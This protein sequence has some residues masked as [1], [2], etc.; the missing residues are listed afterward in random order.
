MSVPCILQAS[1]CFDF[2]GTMLDHLLGDT[3]NKDLSPTQMPPLEQAYAA[4]GSDKPPLRRP[5]VNF[6]RYSWVLSHPLECYQCAPC[7]FR[8]KGSQGCPSEGA[9]KR[10]SKDSTAAGATTAAGAPAASPAGAEGVAGTS[11]AVREPAAPLVE[12]KRR[13]T[14]AAAAAAPSGGKVEATTND[15]RHADGDNTAPGDGQAAGEAAGGALTGGASPGGPGG[16]A[17]GGS[18]AR[19]KIISEPLQ[20]GEARGPGGVWGSVWPLTL[21]ICVVGVVTVGLVF[22]SRSSSGARFKPLPTS[23]ARGEV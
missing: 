17:V 3:P 20:Q 19:S 10:T 4:P 2:L 11:P 23:P 6:T 12:Q 5:D 8:R 7:Q 16:S 14:A 18:E 21:L 15:S 9:W 22:R 1:F 13:E